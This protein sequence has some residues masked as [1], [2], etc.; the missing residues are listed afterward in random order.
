M[1]KINTVSNQNGSLHATFLRPRFTKTGITLFVAQDS[2]GG[3]PRHPEGR[4]GKYLVRVGFRVPGDGLP[5]QNL[6]IE[7]RLNGSSLIF[8]GPNQKLQYTSNDSPKIQAEFVTSS[9]GNLTGA[10]VSLAANTLH[11]AHIKAINFLSPY[12]SYLAF[13]CDAAVEVDCTQVKEARSGNIRVQCLLIGKSVTVDDIDFPNL[14]REISALLSSYREGLNTLNPSWQFLSFWKVME[15]IFFWRDLRSAESVNRNEPPIAFEIFR[16]PT[17]LTDI[18]LEQEESACFV[19]YLG[20]KF[21]SVRTD[22][23]YTHRDAIAHINPKKN[24][25]ET[26]DA[27]A[28]FGVLQAVP[29]LRY[30]AHVLLEDEIVRHIDSFPQTLLLP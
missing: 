15:G 12:I 18:G 11:D 5:I 3:E 13:I 23:E 30:I 21:G 6:E 25:L 17:E 20:K 14:G 7:Q 9:N 1:S 2:E 22:L 8:F 28:L 19:R 16:I 27:D 24:L 26:D 10:V 4:R 29:V